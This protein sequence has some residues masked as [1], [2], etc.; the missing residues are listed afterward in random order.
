MSNMEEIGQVSGEIRIYF[1]YNHGN[2]YSTPSPLVG[3]AI[4]V[5]LSIPI[6]FMVPGY[7]FMVTLIQFNMEWRIMNPIHNHSPLNY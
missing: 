6:D 4:I 7:Y 3:W 2:D 1:L 5:G